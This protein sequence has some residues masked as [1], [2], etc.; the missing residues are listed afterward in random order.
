[1]IN[2]RSARAS[3]FISACL[4]AGRNSDIE[5]VVI[6]GS[7][8]FRTKRKRRAVVRQIGGMEMKTKIALV[9]GVHFLIG[10]IATPITLAI[11]HEPTTHVVEMHNNFFRPETLTIAVGDTVKWV[12]KRARRHTATRTDKPEQFD[13]GL[14]S[15][16]ATF[17]HTFNAASPEGGFQYF[18]RPHADEMIG[19][20]IVVESSADLAVRIGESACSPFDDPDGFAWK[21]FT[22]INHPAD[23]GAGRGVPDESKSIGDD[24]TVVWET[25]KMS[26]DEV[27]LAGGRDPGP[28]DDQDL[29][30]ATGR[31]LLLR[32]P[33]KIDLL[34]RQRVLFDDQVPKDF[35]QSAMN[36]ETYEFIRENELYNIEGQ[37][38]FHEE[39][40]LVNFPAPS[41]EIK[42]AWSLLSETPIG[43]MQKDDLRRMKEGFHTTVVPYGEHEYLFGLRGLHI[44]TKDVPNWVWTTF[45]HKSNLRPELPDNDR[46]GLPNVL[47]GTKWSNYRLRGVQLEFTDS[48]G[49]PTV[50][51]NT[52]MEA[53]F[54][55]SSSCITC[56]ALATIGDREQGSLRA[57]RLPFFHNRRILHRRQIGEVSDQEFVYGDLGVPGLDLFQLKSGKR[58]YT[59]LDFVW[60]LRFAR[61][62]SE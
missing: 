34:K 23:L 9:V 17:Q 32:S 28:W 19:Q 10:C 31:R 20:I 45:E 29:H 41:K 47:N 44:I 56:H 18:C 13:S 24:G 15:Q 14:L 8:Q 62:K 37:E 59:Q 43:E 21:L 6:T 27:Y 40:R 52:Q 61:S 7:E 2:R 54:Q 3:R 4:A 55:Q 49:Q 5:Q 50:L 53:G 48:A 36:R 11:D 57:N 26:P 58:L 46:H 51:A 33:R 12:N 35:G 60:S 30:R 1:M 39:G 42:S 38:A 16:D 22:E 25:W